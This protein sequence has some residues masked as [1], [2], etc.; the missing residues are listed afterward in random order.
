MRRPNVTGAPLVAPLV[1][2]SFTYP[3]WDWTTESQGFLPISEPAQPQY[4][5]TLGAEHMPVWTPYELPHIKTACLIVA[6]TNPG[7]TTGF[8][9]YRVLKNG[10]S[11]ATGSQSVVG[12]AF[13]SHCHYRFF[14][15]KAGDVLA[16]K[17]WADKPN[18]YIH[19]FYRVVVYPT[20]IG[21]GQGDRVIANVTF[22]DPVGA[23]GADTPPSGFV[24]DT[25]SSYLVPNNLAGSV[26]AP[27][28]STYRCLPCEHV[29]GIFQVRNGDFSITTVLGALTARRITDVVI[30]TTYQYTPLKVG[31]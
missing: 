28:L 22:A 29:R 21:C 13:W 15:V 20:R 7:P 16:V 17:T 27:A 18:A 23:T 14:D 2:T 4:S 10:V 3:A 11:V 5:V 25:T 24:R 30:P 26:T 8:I 12:V 31:W 6:G 9:Y 19:D 1:T